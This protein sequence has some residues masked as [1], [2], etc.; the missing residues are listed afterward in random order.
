MN[1]SQIV[2]GR[3]KLLFVTLALPLVCLSACRTVVSPQRINEL[4]QDVFDL[5][6][7]QYRIKPGDVIT[8]DVLGEDLTQ[9]LIVLP[10]GRT[11]P[12]YLNGVLV[13]GKTVVELDA[14]IAA[15]YSGKIVRQPE[16]SIK[17]ESAA[18]VIYLQGQV[19]EAST[20]PYTPNMTLAQAL[21][22]AG[23]YLVT[24]SVDEVILKRPY[25]DIRKPDVF[26]VDLYDQSEEILLL[27]NDEI[28][29]ERTYWI[30]LRDY[31]GE[32][33]WGLLPFNGFFSALLAGGI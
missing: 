2:S 28:I 12:F 29:V 32:Y 10:D 11:D 17:I 27:P 26:F 19:D 3:R 7:A 24:A 16:I 5:R 6:N 21:S 31:L 9:E 13:A 1:T 8:V 20:M 30:L 22:N 18:E 4:Y 23:G 14:E 15:M 25:R 33:I